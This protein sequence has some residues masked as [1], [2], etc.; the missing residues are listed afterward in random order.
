MRSGFKGR[1]CWS[2][3]M[4][5]QRMTCFKTLGGMRMT[6]NE[7]YRAGLLRENN[8][9]ICLGDL[10]CMIYVNEWVHCTTWPDLVW[11]GFGQWLQ[12]H[13]L[14]QPTS[15]RS[16]YFYNQRPRSSEL[17]GTEHSLN[18]VS[19]EFI[20][21]QAKS[22]WIDRIWNTEVFPIDLDF[23]IW[24]LIISGIWK[25]RVRGI[26]SGWELDYRS[27]MMSEVTRGRVDNE[28]NNQSQYLN[29]SNMVQVG[30]IY[31]SEIIAIRTGSYRNMDRNTGKRCVQEG[32][33]RIYVGTRDR[34]RNKN[35]NG[36]GTGTKLE[37]VILRWYWWYPSS[38]AEL[39]PESQESVWSCDSGA[40]RA[41]SSEV[42]LVPGV[43]QEVWQVRNWPRF[44]SKVTWVLW[45][46]TIY[47]ETWMPSSTANSCPSLSALALS[48]GLVDSAHFSYFTQASARSRAVSMASCLS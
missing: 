13:A 35:K 27:W 38:N 22:N 18:R 44:I 14:R 9:W 11:V 16:E 46:I 47:Y 34:N 3:L 48:N 17:I 5:H 23:G 10:L 33:H 36:T 41:D 2:N 4:K 37:T 7:L 8:F 43:W 32:K 20:M 19:I 28:N 30:H 1:G 45:D 39:I 15:C 29:I 26:P 42:E 25:S 24:K 31:K 6:E 12:A 40:S 21:K